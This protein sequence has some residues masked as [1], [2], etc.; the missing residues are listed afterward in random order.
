MK[1]DI[2]GRFGKFILSAGI[3]FK[4]DG[5]PNQKTVGI[6]SKCEDGSHVLFA[7]YDNTL[8]SEVM[9]D[10][11]HVQNRYGVGNCIVLCNSEKY[12]S[13]GKQIGNYLLCFPVRLHFHK[14]RE[15]MQCMRIDKR[16][17]ECCM[18]TPQKSWAIRIAAKHDR[19]TGNIIKP[20]PRFKC[21]VPGV[22]RHKV[23]ADHLNFFR[24]FFMNTPAVKLGGN[25]DVELIN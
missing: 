7:D 25:Y 22:M 4:V 19:K 18:R 3:Y 16:F 20:V 21:L 5:W 17:I 1:F 23:D 24:R 15:I 10:I 8:F 14:V 9:E 11:K 13:N 2:G 12:D 6:T